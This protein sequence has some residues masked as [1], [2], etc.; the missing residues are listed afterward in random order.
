MVDRPEILFEDNHLVVVNK[1]CSDLVQ[2]DKTGDDSLDVLVKAYLKKKYN[3]PGNVFLGVVHRLDRPVSGV[4]V[5]ARTGKA[6]TRM[7]ELFREKKVTKKYWA[8]VENRPPEDRGR[9]EHFLIRK[10][11]K[12]KSYVSF[13]QKPG[14]K[15]AV[16]D[17]RLVGTSRNCFFL[18][19]DLHTGRHHQIRCQLAKMGCPVKKDLKY[20]ARPSEKEGGIY[21]HAREISFIHPVRN[22]KLVVIA[23]PPDY[24]LWN[25]FLKLD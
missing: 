2:G 7:N 19:V 14:A 18:E 17:Y 12:N 20:G 23:P 11:E 8:V 4:V 1:K 15:K 24:L 22:E 25:E 10:P 5:F 3:K 6:L 9:L 21:L 13:R 16:L